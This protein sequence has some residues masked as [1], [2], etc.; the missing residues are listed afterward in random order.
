MS[1]SKGHGVHNSCNVWQLSS[2][3]S[4]QK[5]S[6]WKLFH[7]VWFAIVK[8]YQ[9]WSNSFS[10]VLEVLGI[11]KWSPFFVLVIGSS[12]HQKEKRRSLFDTKYLQNV[13]KLTSETTFGH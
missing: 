2:L 3:F 5:N 11:E 9:P 1:N 13:G 10:H 6:V 4:L 12:D 7:W 8:C